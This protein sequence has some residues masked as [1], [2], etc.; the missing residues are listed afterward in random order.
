MAQSNPIGC[1]GSEALPR[2][3]LKRPVDLDH[4]ARQTSGDPQVEREALQLFVVQSRL[5]LQRLRMAVGERER[6]DTAHSLKGSAAA[7]GAWGV[8]EFSEQLEQLVSGGSERGIRNL[9]GDLEIEIEEICSFVGRL[10][11]EH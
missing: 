11:T 8:A 4:L 5:Y 3:Q 10:Y 7:V 6:L 9:L 2:M 1:G